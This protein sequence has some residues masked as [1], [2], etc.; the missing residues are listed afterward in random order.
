MKN[1]KKIGLALSGG[2]YRA[3]IYHIGTL[4]KLNELGILDKVDVISTISG[5]SIT[6]A[7]YCL[8][9]GSY[10]DFENRTK[11]AVKKNI[12]KGIFTSVKMLPVY[13][14][15]LASAYII[16]RLLYTNYPWT[17]IIYIIAF[18]LIILKYQYQ[19]FPTSD[20]IDSLY[21]KW[22]FDGKN[23]PD[24]K[25]S[26][27][28][29]IN[30]TNTESG[31]QFTFSRDY[32]GDSYYTFPEDK[33]DKVYFVNSNF[34]VSKAVA[35]STCV[36]FAFSPIRI[37]KKYFKD[38][39]YFNTVYPCLVDGG[40]YDNQGLHKLT[41]SNSRFYCDVIIVSDAGN[42]MKPIETY[43]NLIDLVARTCDIFM[44]RIKNV[45]MIQNLYTQNN[46]S[47]RQIAYQSLGWDANDC[48]Q[49]FM[50]NLKKG[51]I[52]LSVIMEHNI[53]E[54]AIKNKQWT[55]IESYIKQKIDYDKIMLQEPTESEIK[56]ARNVVTQLKPL[57]DAEM[58]AL[59]KQAY[60]ITEMQVKLYC[61]SIV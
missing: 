46:D 9:N 20:V 35:S 36:P 2:G 43:T 56:L 28:I 45:Q 32:M 19:L 31:R 33:T 47:N 37:G 25:K 18:I 51:N 16:Y 58:N 54:E 30:A 15:T 10:E 14:F 42:K 8:N 26:P 3:T 4:R 60:C 52:P 23:L 41:Q 7:L 39:K 53:S 13:L 38:P 50:E 61:P 27:M 55:E 34:P 48:L 24:L 57:P 6:G 5:G 17:A 44:N 22:F 40:V 29:A 59:I 1:S 12:I 49:G 11:Q 21:S